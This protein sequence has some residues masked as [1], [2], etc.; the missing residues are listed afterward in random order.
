MTEQHYT[1]EMNNEGLAPGWYGGRVLR[2]DGTSAY[3][4]MG[5]DKDSVYADVDIMTNVLNDE[6][7]QLQ[8]R[9]AELEA[10][11]NKLRKSLAEILMTYDEPMTDDLILE[12]IIDIAR[13]ALGG[14]E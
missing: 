5:Q 13:D 2:V 12:S 7:A 9:I 14:A 11:K 1:H 3:Q 4:Y 6:F 8:A 10:Q